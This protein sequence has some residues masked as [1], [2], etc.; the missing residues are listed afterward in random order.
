MA[1]VQILLK[2]LHTS[3]E[4]AVPADKLREIPEDLLGA[5]DSPQNHDS[6]GHGWVSRKSSVL[7]FE[8]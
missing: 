8:R 2:V 4:V 3:R 6:F 7:T 5:S 1:A